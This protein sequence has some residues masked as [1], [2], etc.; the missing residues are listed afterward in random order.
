[1]GLINYNVP[2]DERNQNKNIKAN[3]LS[4]EEM[5]ELGFN[6]RLEGHWFFSERVGPPRAKISFSIDIKKE[7]REVEVD[8]LDEN[9]VQPYD[10]QYF[11]ALDDKKYETAL[12][13]H[14]DVQKLMKKFME[15]GIIDGYVEGDFI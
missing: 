6:D 12:T 8:I 9:Y 11:L 15:I 14:R 5:R 1:M 13:V 4:D 3:I 7:T 2:R 10:Y